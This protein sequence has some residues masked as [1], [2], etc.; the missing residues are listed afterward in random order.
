MQ[1]DKEK[2]LKHIIYLLIGII[3][4]LIII[5]FN[6]PILDVVTANT[7][8]RVVKEYLQAMIEGDYEKFISLQSEDEVEQYARKYNL[9]YEEFTKQTKEQFAVLHRAT[10]ENGLTMSDYKITASSSY[11]DRTLVYVKVEYLGYN[12]SIA[13]E[14]YVPVKKD[15]NRVWYIPQ[16]KHDYGNLNYDFN[17]VEG[18]VQEE[19]ISEK[20]EELIDGTDNKWHLPEDY[21]AE[22]ISTDY[23]EPGMVYYEDLDGDGQSEE[24][25][26]MVTYGYQESY[27]ID[28]ISINQQNY[29]IDKIDI[30]VQ[31]CIVDIDK[32]D[33]F[34]EIAISTDG[35]S[36]DYKTEFYRYENGQIEQIG[37]VDGKFDEVYL[38]N[39]YYKIEINGDGLIHTYIIDNNL[40]TYLYDVTY[41]LTDDGMELVYADY[42]EMDTEVILLRDLDILMEPIKY[43]DIAHTI[44]KGEKAYLR[45]Y[46][47]DFVT[48]SGWYYIENE[49]KQGGW[50][51]VEDGVVWPIE[52]N[53]YEV[54]EGLCMAD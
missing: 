32:T 52:Y 10:V 2:R 3:I 16:D 48:D 45:A 47:G 27:T 18:E 34:M 21:V 42:Y 26:L 15:L 38:L 6:N 37:Y 51:N 5:S 43:S 35:Y 49:Q 22:N 7:P 24:I 53:T 19:T 46:C 29:S 23:Y 17:K 20:N 28:G 50:F 40:Q 25:Q 13:K 30:P 8:E 33:C 39:K 36:S 31:L 9:T 41:R 44:W 14:V 1:Q 54:F 12:E 11:Q 4:L